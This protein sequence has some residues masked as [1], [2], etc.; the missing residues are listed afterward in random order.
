MSSQDSSHKTV[1]D[2][3]H[4]YDALISGGGPVGLVLALGLAMQEKTAVLLEKNHPERGEKCSFDGR[5]LALS[6]GSQQVLLQLGVWSDLEPYVTEIE[7]V[8]V[9]QKGYLGLT[10]L[11][12]KEVNVPALGYSITA[13]DLGRVLWQ[14]VR[15]HPHIHVHTGASI[16][17]LERSASSQ[18]ITFEQRQQFHVCRAKLVVGADGTGS[19]VRTLLNLK[20]RTKKYDAFGVIA[21]IETEKLPDGWA[22]ERFTE[23]GP[24]ALLPMQ[25]HFSKA[26][27]VVPSAE[28]ESIQTL[29]DDAFMAG[30]SARMGERFGAYVS[31]SERVTYPLVE[32]YVDPFYAERAVLMGNAAHTQHPVAA[33]GLN[34][35]IQDIQEFL[36]K[37]EVAEDIGEGALLKDY[38]ESRKAA[39]E[40]VMG[41]TDGLIQLFQTES[42]VVG[43]LRGLGLMA[44]NVVPSLR[45]RFTKMA[46]GRP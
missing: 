17:E 37:S 40:K 29:D 1:F 21:K 46:M 15:Q 23:S 31:V 43:H 18:K 42:P 20:M 25:G 11:H 10:L 16:S 26:V 3:D 12:A 28:I 39:H 32:T 44:M 14:K 6:Y 33:Q 8:H 7:H 36:E 13:E 2:D 4:L 5:V 35:G 45:K 9:S 30:F 19:K 24:V 34:L 27:W 22:F 41:M 38:A